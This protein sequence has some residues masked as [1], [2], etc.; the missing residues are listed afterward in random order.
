MVRR[1][2]MLRVV[3]FTLT[4]QVSLS[5]VMVVM[6]WGGLWPTSLAFAGFMVW[7]TGVFATAGLTMGN[8][9]AMAMERLGHLA[10]LA[11]TVMLASATIMGAVLAAPLA[12]AFDGTAGPLSLGVLVAAGLALVLVR[13][14]N[15]MQ[16]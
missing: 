12:L 11:A 2:G 9:G 5:A 16:G 13:W 14:A 1:I 3:M 15:R 7:I 4:A 10:G 8:L 6:T